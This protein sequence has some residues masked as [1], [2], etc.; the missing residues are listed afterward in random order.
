MSRYRFEA[1]ALDA[2]AAGVLS[3]WLDRLLRDVVLRAFPLAAPGGA[4]DDAVHGLRVALRRLSSV[5]SSWE[6]VYGARAMAPLL[7]E[8]RRLSR[9]AGKARDAE[10]ALAALDTLTLAP[11]VGDALQPHAHALREIHR[12]RVRKL[13]RPLR[14]GV[15]E[16]AQRLLALQ[17]RSLPARKPFRAA[18]APLLAALIEEIETALDAASLDGDSRPAH[19]AR[20]LAKRLRYLLDPLPMPQAT[21]AVAQLAKLQDRLG[22]LHDAQLLQARMADIELP[23]RART[24]IDTVLQARV[25]EAAA[26]AAPLLQRA[27]R[28]RLSASLARLQQALM[29]SPS[30]RPAR[31]SRTS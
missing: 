11:D 18:F 19:D 26:A 13:A 1:S 3:R 10:V 5:L 23:R 7:A 14:E 20:L 6:P 30:R 25:A 12:R 31:T 16:L 17:P 15:P 21:A 28:R 2:P 8:I 24:V 4:P 29:A 27:A 9:K 22:E